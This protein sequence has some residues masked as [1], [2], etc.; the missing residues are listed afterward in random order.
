MGRLVRCALPDT[1]FTLDNGENGYDSISSPANPA[2]LHRDRS[3]APAAFVSEHRAEGVVIPNG[4]HRTEPTAHAVKAEPDTV[5]T[6]CDARD[7]VDV[8]QPQGEHAHP[9]VPPSGTAVQCK[10]ERDRRKLTP[11]ATAVDVTQGRPKRC[12]LGE[13][14]RTSLFINHPALPELDESGKVIA[15]P[16]V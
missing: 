16:K 7:S 9:Q 6:Q 5:T 15:R 11:P 3:Q 13:L 4:H 14:A 8:S 10:K 1:A 2:Q 12:G